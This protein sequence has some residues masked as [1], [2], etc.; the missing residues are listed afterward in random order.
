MTGAEK[1]RALFLR[2]GQNC[3]QSVLAAFEDEIGIEKDKLLEAASGFGGGMAGLGETCGAVT[4]MYMAMGFL[5]GYIKSLDGIAKERLYGKLGEMTE[6][7]KAEY[8]SIKCEDLLS[9]KLPGQEKKE[10]CSRFVECA[11]RLV[12]QYKG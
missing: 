1:A 2:D 5:Q 7:F 4:G 9:F 11:A 10:Y 6:K 12:E 3:A 8:K